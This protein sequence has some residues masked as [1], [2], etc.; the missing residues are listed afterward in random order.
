SISILLLLLVF[1][2]AF[3]NIYDYDVWFHIKA[4]E[5]MLSNFE[6]LSRDVFSYTALD[7]PWV[8]HEWLFEVMLYIIAAIGSLV[9]VTVFKAAVICA[10]FAL[11][12]RHF[13][14]ISISMPVT[15]VFLTLASLLARE[16]FIERPEIISYLFSAAFIVMLE[17]IRR[18]RTGL[19]SWKDDR[20]WLFPVLM[21]LWANFHS[22]AIFA[23]AI[24]GAYASG[25]ILSSLAKGLFGAN[26]MSLKEIIGGSVKL[27]VFFSIFIAIFFVGFLNPNTLHVYTYPFLALDISSQTGLNL[28]EYTKPLWARDS[29]FFISFAISL[30]IILINIIFNRRA[31]VLA[32]MMLYIFFSALALKFNRNIAIWAIVVVPFIAFYFEEIISWWSAVS[33][34]H[35]FKGEGLKVARGEKLP[36]RGGG[37]LRPLILVGSII[38]SIA[39]VA[40]FVVS[41]V[42]SNSWGPGIKEGRFPEAAIS[43]L[44]D[45]SITG[46]MF[47]SYEFGGYIL[48]RSY[49]ERMV[50]ID[51]RSDIYT[52][53]LMEQKKLSILG[54]EKLI[55]KYDVNYLIMSYS[56]TTA[57]YVNPNPV[58]GSELALIWFDDVSMVYLR[59]TD[60]NEELIRRYEYRYVRPADTELRFTNLN[61]PAQLASELERNIKESPGGWRSRALLNELYRRFGREG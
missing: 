26:K 28:A 10:I 47:N 6:I 16:R 19:I 31:I 14:R 58:F 43:F 44:D 51:G 46:N 39:M 42:Q 11:Y 37:V 17:T 59:R 23:I 49:P 1:S 15:I 41:T 54:F 22:G 12:L 36:V 32:H 29:L 40:P 18:N 4:G 45:N 57:G 52:E 21:V 61:E 60:E 13:R 55:E 30:I 50:Y 7:S 48:W 34:S 25:E 56:K 38:L 35:P 8:A 33:P 24:C 20:L 3:V 9:A 2:Q 27:R 5:Y 53:L